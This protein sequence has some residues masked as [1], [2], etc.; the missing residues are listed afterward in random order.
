MKDSLLENVYRVEMICRIQ[1]SG[2]Q[3]TTVHKL[4]C[5]NN[6]NIIYELI[7]KIALKVCS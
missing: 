4:C 1:E 5:L 2:A 7:F 6:G 3:L